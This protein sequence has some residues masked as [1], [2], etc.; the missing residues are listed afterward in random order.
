VAAVA[1]QSSVAAKIAVCTQAAEM[2]ERSDDGLGL[3]GPCAALVLDAAGSPYDLD[4]GES[5][6][7]LLAGMPWATK[8]SSCCAPRTTPWARPEPARK[9]R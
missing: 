2:F 4:P 3:V 7:G 8:R 9:E 6:E 1:S 5:V